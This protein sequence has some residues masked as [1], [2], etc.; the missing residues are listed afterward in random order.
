MVPEPKAPT[1]APPVTIFREPS[2]ASAS[3]R[4]RSTGRWT[5]RWTRDGNFYVLDA[6]NNRVQKFDS[7]SNFVLSWGVVRLPA[8]GVHQP[9]GDRRRPDGRT[10]I[11]LRR[12]H[13]EPPDPDLRR[14]E[15]QPDARRATD[16]LSFLDKLGQ[17]RQPRAATSRSPRDIAFDADGNIW[18]LDAGNERVQKFK[19]DP[20]D[21]GPEVLRRRVG[22]LVRH[23]RGRVHRPGVDRLV[24]DRLGYIYLLGAG[25]LVQQFQLD[26]TLVNSWPAI[27]PESGLCAPA[28]I[29]IDNKDD[30]VYVLDAGNGL[31]ERFN[32]DGRFLC[33]LRGAERPFS[34]PLGLAVNPDRDEVLV[35]DTENNIVQKFTLR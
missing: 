32:L 21:R 1:P 16:R 30:Y 11:H 20:E 14:F 17:P 24:R 8:G 6:G 23:P 13:R 5:S 28:R 26:G 25:C 29:E 12:R 34:N 33:A 4:V 9:R 35:A 18:V 22:Q 10:S 7:F 2:G 15:K 31:F 3:G 27:A 19:F